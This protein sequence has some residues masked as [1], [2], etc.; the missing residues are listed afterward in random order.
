MVHPQRDRQSSVARAAASVVESLEQRRLL[1]AAPGSFGFAISFGTEDEVASGYAVQADPQGNIYVAGQFRGLIDVNFSPTGTRMLKS[2]GDH[3]D[4]FL[5]KYNANGKLIWGRRMGGPDDDTVGLLKLAPDGDVVI[6]GTF[7]ATANIGSDANPYLLHTRGSRDGF[8]ARFDGGTGEVRWGGR[9]G[10]DR[11]DATTALAV[12][13]DNDVYIAGTVRLNGNLNPSNT[14]KGINIKTLGVDDSYLER[15]DGATGARKWSKVWGENDTREAILSMT[16]DNAGNIFATGMFNN[17]VRFDRNNPAFDREA[18]DADDVFLAKLKPDGSWAW[19]KS[20]GGENE[21]SVANMV[22]GSN[23]DLYLTGNFRK[24]AN[25]NPVGKPVIMTSIGDSDAYVARF[26]NNGK[27]VWARQFGGDGTIVARAIGVDAA[28]NVYS[29]G[30]FINQMDFDP[31]LGIR[32]FDPDK[33]SDAVAV[34][35]EPDITEGYVSKLDANGKFKYI[36]LIG[37][38]DAGMA[39][40]ALAATPAGNVYVTGG[41]TNVANFNNGTTH[42]V[43]RHTSSRKKE[44]DAFILKLNR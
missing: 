15:L 37:G 2:L 27:L 18:Q 24:D 20:F 21:E 5:A 34:P 16:V 31:G 28:G 36:R 8:V 25:F 39:D 9:I 17:T 19:I 30:E 35:G 41:F 26:H 40:Y 13:P 44:V 4:I 42:P 22:M 11:D 6:A 12:G 29:T 1:A 33:S 14:G 7:Q 10:G 23:G 32:S 38:E 43:I 3:S